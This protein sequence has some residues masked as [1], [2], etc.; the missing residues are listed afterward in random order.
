MTV[1][2]LSIALGIIIAIVVLTTVFLATQIGKPR[3]T[4]GTRT[5]F[6]VTAVINTAVCIVLV[7]TIWQLGTS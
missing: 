4:A 3:K 2:L 7:L 6:A 1:I 5:S